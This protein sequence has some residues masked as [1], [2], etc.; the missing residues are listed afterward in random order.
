MLL[1]FMP[2]FSIRW[3]PADKP[4]WKYPDPPFTCGSETDY[5]NINLNDTYVCQHRWDVVR[6]MVAFANVVQ[7]TSVDLIRSSRD[8]ISFSRGERGFFAMGRGLSSQTGAFSVD[9]FF[10][11][12]MQKHL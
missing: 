2:T 9:T 5:Y 3:R 7:G 8:A 1:A 10:N 4:N 6:A 12:L 11:N